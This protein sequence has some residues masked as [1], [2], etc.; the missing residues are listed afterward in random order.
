MAM[1]NGGLSASDALLLGSGGAGG[2]RVHLHGDHGN[3]FHRIKG[4]MSC[5]G[6]R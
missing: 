3:Q 2:G 5:A 4:G 6:N 1:E